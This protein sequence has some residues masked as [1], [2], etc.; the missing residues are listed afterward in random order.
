MSLIEK[1]EEVA[2]L[3]GDVQASLDAEDQD[4]ALKRIRKLDEAIKRVP[5]DH[6]LAGYG[7]GGTVVKP[8]HEVG[9]TLGPLET[10][11]SDGN[12][13]GKARGEF[14]DSVKDLDKAIKHAKGVEE[15][16]P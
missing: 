10:E 3:A 16:K 12:F 2:S 11:V 1:A 6:T 7:E 15:G 9:G 5:R 4:E 8:A 13:E 14:D